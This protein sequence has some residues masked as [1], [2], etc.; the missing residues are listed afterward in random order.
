MVGKG[1]IATVG[2]T[3]CDS[4]RKDQLA[5]ASFKTFSDI[6]IRKHGEQNELDTRVV[7]AVNAGYWVSS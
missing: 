7:H 4:C 6:E 1:R 3:I 5:K 2:V